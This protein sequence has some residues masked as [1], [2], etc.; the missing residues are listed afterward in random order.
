MTFKRDPGDVSYRQNEPLNEL[1]LCIRV[2]LIGLM[3]PWGA[4]SGPAIPIFVRDKYVTQYPN[5]A[6]H[7]LYDASRLSASQSLLALSMPDRGKQPC[8]STTPALMHRRAARP[9]N[10]SVLGISVRPR[11]APPKACPKIW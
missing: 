5:S 1:A 3:S 4:G 2:W 8:Q 11:E 10:L 7:Y 6:L 9:H